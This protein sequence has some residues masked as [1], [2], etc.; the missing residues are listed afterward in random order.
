MSNR[1][2]T[3]MFNSRQQ[4]EKAA[5]TLASETGLNRSE[6]RISPESG[7]TDTGY[8]KSKPYAET[9]YFGSLRNLSVADEDRYAFAEG[10][11]RGAVLMSTQ[12]DDSKIDH[13][14]SILEREQA[15]DLDEQEAS[16]RKSGWT[17]YDE[18]AHRGATASTTTATSGTASPAMRQPATRTMDDK[19]NVVEERLVV[20]KR[21]VSRGGVRIRS[22]VVERPVEEQVTLHDETVKVDR[23]PVDRAITPAD[24]KLFQERTI[25]ARGTH[26][27]AVVQ[28]EARVVE[29]IGVH[30]EASDHVE[31]VRDTVRRTQVDVEGENQ[32]TGSSS[33]TGTGAGMTNSSG[34]PDGTPGN[35]PGTMASRG[36]DK[37][38]GTNVSGANP[39]R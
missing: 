35:P 13:A 5:S 19:I 7:A 18:A 15:L 28:K 2:I 9:G 33:T 30:K 38:L 12:I 27:E 4:A 34:A 6:I 16:W 17:G 20:G 1:T 26:E 31:T 29:E 37:V 8:D 14:A 25:E 3:A 11:R 24:E 39:K 23:R 36:V 21:E 32:A 10:M 22:Y